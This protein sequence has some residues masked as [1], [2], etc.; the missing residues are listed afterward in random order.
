MPAYKKLY[1]FLEAGNLTD[2]EVISTKISD[3]EQSLP[4]ELLIRCFRYCRPDFFIDDFNSIINHP[5]LELL[6]RHY[7]QSISKNSTVNTLT[8]QLIPESFEAFSK[9]FSKI[10]LTCGSLQTTALLLR[11]RN[12]A[13]K[14]DYP[15]LGK[16][17]TEHI[18]GYIGYVSIRNKREKN[19][20]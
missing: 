4:K 5:N 13:L 20:L 12:L 1:Q 15:V 2:E 18:E 11:S 6:S 3:I 14:S 10:V 17:L 7:C 16:Y 8:V 9:D 19:L